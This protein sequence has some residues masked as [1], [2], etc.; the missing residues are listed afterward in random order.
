MAGYGTDQGL[1][2]WLATNGFT[3]P[4]GAPTLAVLRERGSGYVDAVYGWRFCGYP[5]GGIDQDRAWPR[6]GMEVFG[7]ALGDTV[8]PNAIVN[9]SYRAAWLEA[10]IPGWT[11]T[12]VDPSRRIK[13]QKVEGI[14]R[15][16]FGPETIEFRAG[17]FAR[18]D[19]EI[20]GLLAAFLCDGRSFPT[21]LVV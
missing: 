10:S 20:E 14:E 9:A 16:F 8:I 19:G 1:T 2:D 7:Q 21:V 11:S 18:I 5:T 13:R 17:N 15:E 3:L 12:T 6:T 4:G